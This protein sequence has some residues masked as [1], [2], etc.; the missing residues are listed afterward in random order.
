MTS[1]LLSLLSVAVMTDVMGP[2]CLNGTQSLGNFCGPRRRRSLTQVTAT[3][4]TPTWNPRRH[5]TASRTLRLGV[6]VHT[7]Y[8]LRTQ[9][10][11]VQPAV[12]ISSK[13]QF[14]TSRAEFKVRQHL[15]LC[16][17]AQGKVRVNPIHVQSLILLRHYFTC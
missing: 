13:T 2:C 3:F 6:T 1:S 5:S 17:T 12:E 15:V 11:S 7:T 4:Y 10:S 16:G 14:I 9:L 8:T